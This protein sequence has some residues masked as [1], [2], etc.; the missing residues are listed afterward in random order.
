MSKKG[1]VSLASWPKFDGKILTE[2]S[3]FKWKLMN[4]IIDDINSIILIRKKVE[5]K[6]NKIEIVVADDWKFTF[7]KI[8]MS[9]VEKTKNQG[10]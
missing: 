2:E 3:N 6:I 10:M 9:L 7:Y 1:Y 5:G 8:F 4:N